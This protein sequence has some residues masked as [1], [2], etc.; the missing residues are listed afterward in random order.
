[1][2]HGRQDALPTADEV[3]APTLLVAVH[4]HVL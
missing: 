1:M 2:D 4:L 3:H